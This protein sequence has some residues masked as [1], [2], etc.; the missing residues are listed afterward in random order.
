[1]PVRIYSAGMQTRLSFAIATS[2]QPDILLMDDTIINSQLLTIPH[3]L[4]AER[5]FALTP[6]TEIAADIM[7][8]VLHTSIKELLAECKDNLRVYKI[9][10]DN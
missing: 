7:H 6:L 9:S 2:M 1:M 10:P 3:P 8:P 4:L 5:R